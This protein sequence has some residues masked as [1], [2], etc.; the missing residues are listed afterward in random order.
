[1]IEIKGHFLAIA[2]VLD[3]LGVPHAFIGGLGR[4]AWGQ[5][6]TTE[7]V[8]VQ[9]AVDAAGWRRCV[10]ALATAG[11][12][13]EQEY[14]GHDG[15]PPDNAR[16]RGLDGLRVDIMLDKTRFQ[17]DVVRRATVQRVAG[18]S[19]RVL[20]PEDLVLYKLIASRPKDLD[21]IEDVL[22]GRQLAGLPVDWAYIEDHAAEWCMLA[23]VA[24]LKARFGG[25]P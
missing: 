23:E 16:L 11:Y 3:D 25:A 5:P 17:K 6:R 13:L 4:N 9:I 24:R 8:D 22:R 10:E 2:A 15:P 1:M 12:R 20:T 14:G 7:D 19:L 21:D 18:M